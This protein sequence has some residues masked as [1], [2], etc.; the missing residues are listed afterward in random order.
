MISTKFLQRAPKETCS[1]SLFCILSRIMSTIKFQSN[2]RS[3][4]L[5]THH[6]RPDH[7]P[8]NWIILLTSSDPPGNRMGEISC[9]PIWPVHVHPV[10]GGIRKG[11]SAHN[12]NPGKDTSNYAVK[13]IGH[14]D[15]TY[16]RN[17]VAAGC[18]T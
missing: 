5:P 14:M 3:S 13:V 9:K 16:T 18:S 7:F 1:N 12:G 11:R 2:V 8:C 17:N 4:I 10:N 6:V 15:I